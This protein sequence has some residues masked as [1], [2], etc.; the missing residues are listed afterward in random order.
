MFQMSQFL[1]HFH[2]PGR[3]MSHFNY[4][5]PSHIPIFIPYWKMLI[6]LKSL[7]KP[8]RRWTYATWHQ[9]QF[10]FL[11]LAPHTILTGK[12]YEY[13]LLQLKSLDRNTHC[14][15]NKVSEMNVYTKMIKNTGASLNQRSTNYWVL[16]IVTS[17]LIL[18]FKF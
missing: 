17:F 10:V 8:N 11:S 2:L 18:H 13:K 9:L 5:L 12:K 15:S 3:V 4:K 6:H 16:K 14:T 7:N 1:V